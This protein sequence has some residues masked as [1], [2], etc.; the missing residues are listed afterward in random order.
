MDHDDEEQ[1]LQV[2]LR[3]LD[4]VGPW[5]KEVN[6][7][8]LLIPLFLDHIRMHRL[9]WYPNLFLPKLFAAIVFQAE[10][11]TTDQNNA[12]LFFN[13]ILV[14]L[15]P[16]HFPLEI[17]W[18]VL[19]SLFQT[20]SKDALRFWVIEA[21]AGTYYNAR[22]WDEVTQ[23]EISL[24]NLKYRNSLLY[25]N[26]LLVLL[27]SLVTFTQT[28]PP[29][30]LLLQVTDILEQRR[31]EEKSIRYLVDDDEPSIAFLYRMGT[32]LDVNFGGAVVA[33]LALNKC[34]QND[35]A[36]AKEDFQAVL[37]TLSK[38]MRARLGLI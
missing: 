36:R 22:Y 12:S 30:D 8:V 31:K 15:G 18:P 27:A 28:I 26:L 11:E 2:V 5:W 19:R 4:R 33:R 16:E 21:R 13:H 25:P 32:A 35:T 23:R 7:D 9:H 17:V 10:L 20:V 14:G 1:Q 6:N 38:P 24:G 34:Y 37:L 29:R 3:M